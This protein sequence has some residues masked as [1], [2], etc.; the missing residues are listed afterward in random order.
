MKMSFEKLIEERIGEAIANGEFDNL[1]GMGRPVN[2]EAYFA[3]PEHV[4][5]GY[6]ILK[7]AGFVPEEVDLL[8]EIQRLKAELGQCADETRKVRINAALNETTLKFNLLMDRYRRE[9]RT[10]CY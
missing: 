4:R 3:T 2:L 7:S 6:S 9:R 8:K 1:P 5:I 10:P